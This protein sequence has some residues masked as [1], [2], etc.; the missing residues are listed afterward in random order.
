[1]R[2]GLVRHDPTQ[3]LL[4]S[5]EEIEILGHLEGEQIA[6]IMEEGSFQEVD[7]AFPFAIG[8]GLRGQHMEEL[9]FAGTEVPAVECHDELRRRLES[10]LGSRVQRQVGLEDASENEVGVGRRRV[11]EGNGLAGEGANV[12]D[13]RME[14]GD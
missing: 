3:A 6:R 10:G 11:S 5:E 2:P 12:C 14:Q 9:A 8:P 1:M 4:V 13:G 7:G